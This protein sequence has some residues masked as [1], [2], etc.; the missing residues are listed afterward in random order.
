MTRKSRGCRGIAAGIAAVVVAGLMAG[1]ASFGTGSASGGAALT[2]NKNFSIDGATIVGVKLLKSDGHIFAGYY[3]AKNGLVV[4]PHYNI[5]A[6]DKAK[7][8]A[9]ISPKW[10]TNS[11]D[12]G[13][14]EKIIKVNGHAA[15]KGVK[16][17]MT[18]K[19]ALK[20]LEK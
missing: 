10:A 12:Q 7:I 1:C 2:E 11:L 16:V 4:C 5:E 20:L 17:G 8:P 6:M 9:A 14:N 13:L 18:V 3:R 19:E 15:A